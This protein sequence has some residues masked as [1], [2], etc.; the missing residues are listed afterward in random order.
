MPDIDPD[1]P[2]SISITPNEVIK[3]PDTRRALGKALYIVSLVAG[4]A[5]LFFASFPEFG[6]DVANRALLF[7]TSAVTLVSGAFGLTVTTPNV[8]RQH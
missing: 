5:A 1:E 2:G 8:P 3:N 6:G 4:V 7:I